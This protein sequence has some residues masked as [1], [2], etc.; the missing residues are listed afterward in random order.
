MVALASRQE[1]I[2]L[3]TLVGLSILMY[4]LMQARSALAR[5]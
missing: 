1:M 3:A 4:L 2:G 5:E